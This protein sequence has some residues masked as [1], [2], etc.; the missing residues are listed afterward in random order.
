MLEGKEAAGNI[1]GWSSSTHID[2]SGKPA[3]NADRER[4]AMDYP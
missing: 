4:H 1:M 2:H 3:S